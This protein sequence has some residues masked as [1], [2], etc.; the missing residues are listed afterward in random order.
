M[1]S[2]FPV[3]CLPL[4]LSHW[5]IFYLHPVHELH[6]SCLDDRG[7]GEGNG[8]EQYFQTPPSWAEEKE[9]E[10]E[11]KETRCKGFTTTG[12]FFSKGC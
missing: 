10:L 12:Q 5:L 3:F 6:S 8:K 9:E 7:A 1:F 11:E 2:G 4:L